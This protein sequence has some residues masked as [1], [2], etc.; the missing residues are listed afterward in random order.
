MDTTFLGKLKNLALVFFSSLSIDE[1]MYLSQLITEGLLL[2]GFI[3][4]QGSM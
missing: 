2:L 3:L 1:K 4:I